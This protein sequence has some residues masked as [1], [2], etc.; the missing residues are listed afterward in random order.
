MGHP[1]KVWSSPSWTSPSPVMERQRSQGLPDAP[2]P[3]PGTAE[4]SCLLPSSIHVGTRPPRPRPD[5]H[6]GPATPKPRAPR[7]PPRPAQGYCSR[8]AVTHGRR[9][10]PQGAPLTTASSP[11][12]EATQAPPEGGKSPP[13]TDTPSEPTSR[14]HP[15]TPNSDPTPLHPH[16]PAGQHQWPP[17]LAM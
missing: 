9:Q 17:T 14:E 10:D 4:C 5:P 2:E 15:D 16:H 1:G 13:V 6:T 11:P 7:P 3:W 12:P 8:Q